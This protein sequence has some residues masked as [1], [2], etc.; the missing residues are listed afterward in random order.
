ME[1]NA[2]RQLGL[3]RVSTNHGR[4]RMLSRNISRA[5]LDDLTTYGVTYHRHGL[6]FY[7]L[8]RRQVPS[9]RAAEFERRHLV[10]LV[11]IFADG[12]LVT[13]YKNADAPRRV[14][15]R[16]K[17]SP[18]PRHARA[19]LHQNLLRACSVLTVVHSSFFDCLGSA[20]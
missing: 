3:G 4:V 14:R 2:Y 8:G 20:A 12:V 19:C 15:R 6:V 10:G 18:V 7:V 5:D 17:R 9:A 11:G 13:T 1:I 16:S